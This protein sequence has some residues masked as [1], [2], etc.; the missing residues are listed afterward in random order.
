MRPIV[1]CIQGPTTEMARF[2]ATVLKNI[3]YTFQFN[4]KNWY[5]V[6][7]KLRNVTIPPGYSLV[8]FDVVSLFTNVPN[9]AKFSI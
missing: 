8:S 3:E 6:V 7:E 4:V 9:I 2:V 5:E 1:S